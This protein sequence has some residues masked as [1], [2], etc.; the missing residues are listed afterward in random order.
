M[1]PYG[2]DR[3]HGALLSISDNAD[4][5]ATANWNFANPK[6]SHFL[7]FPSHQPISVLRR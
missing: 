1:K 7:T 6:Q 5:E 4:N 2:M 3:L